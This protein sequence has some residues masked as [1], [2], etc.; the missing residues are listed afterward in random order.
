VPAALLL[1]ISL[2]VCSIRPVHAAPAKTNVLFIVCDDLCTELGCYGKAVVRTPN[3]D[4]LMSKG[5]RFEHAYAQ[6]PLCNPSRTSFLS[7]LR[8]E[9]SGVI[10]QDMVLRKMKPD[11]L[12]L[13]EHFRHN[14]Y[15]VA[16]AGKV[17]HHNDPQS[18]EIYDEGRAISEQ[19]LAAEKR[20]SAERK[21]GE[22]GPE[23][24]RLDCTDED[25]GDGVVAKQVIGYIEHAAKD[26]KPFFVA[27]GFRKPHLPWTA[28]TKYFEMYPKAAIH[29]D[30]DPPMID[31]P[32]LALQ[33]DLFGA[34]QP[35]ERWEAV[36]GYY[37]C[38]SFVDAQVGKLLEEMDQRKL[39][40]NTVVVFLGDN[41]YHLG[42][43]GGLWAKLTD[44]ERA[45]RIPL[46]VI[47]P[48]A[49]GAGKTSA[50]LVEL[51]DLYPTLTE[52]CGLPAPKGL[53]G[54]SLFPLLNDP[55]ATWGL[56]AYTTTVHEGTIGRSVR[57]EH[58]RFTL[59]GD[60]SKGMELYDQDTDPED[61][62]NIAK[63]PSFAATV[64][65]MK[66]LLD[67]VPHVT[68]PIPNSAQSEG[69]QAKKKK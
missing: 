37:A 25:T 53:E 7:G 59:W 44:F 24:T 48:G 40:D 26:N 36:A 65:E 49:P 6:Y 52:A 45:A 42:D 51:L 3:I 47:T 43:H 16:G 55:S 28:P 57:T 17:F 11:V 15:F 69:K 68:G 61:F 62:N 27:A 32:Q 67:K 38:I 20:R 54:K 39:W 30:P 33:T 46:G 14:G 58:Y 13:P 8:P 2:V 10:G 1:F 4:R 66:L 31:V 60:G 29:L 35:K 23:W 18:W 64:S 12:F 63:Q 9:T 56:P 41:G 50:K 21:A 19:Q 34:P 5:V 22:A